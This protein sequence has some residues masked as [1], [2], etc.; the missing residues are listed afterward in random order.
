MVLMQLVQ[1]VAVQKCSFVHVTGI[2]GQ[3]NKGHLF[4][5]LTNANS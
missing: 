4:L 5:F 3:E 2:T 1:F